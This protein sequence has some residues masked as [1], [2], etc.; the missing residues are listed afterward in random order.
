MAS[1]APSTTAQYRW[2]GDP[3][4][5]V[6][7]VSIRYHTSCAVLATGQARCWGEHAG[8]GTQIERAWAVPV[9]AP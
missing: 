2:R 1:N 9:I 5:D 7:A 4:S 8:D 3:L 6:R